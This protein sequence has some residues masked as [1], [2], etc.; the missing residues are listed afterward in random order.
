[1]SNFYEQSG[2]AGNDSFIYTERSFDEGEE[3]YIM[4]HKDRGD[5][6]ILH[7]GLANIGYNEDPFDNNIGKVTIG[8]N[9]LSR[10]GVIFFL[11]RKV[12]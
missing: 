3:S 4:L 8:D 10:I 7:N 2:D 6:D 11:Q 12:N 5:S 1:M 9:V